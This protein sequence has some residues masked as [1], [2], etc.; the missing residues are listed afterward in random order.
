MADI[1]Y[2]VD[3]QASKGALSQSFA[4]SGVTANMS[5]AGIMSVTLNLGT[6][7]TQISTANMNV[8][9]ICI[10]RSLATSTTHTVSFGRYT[11]GTLYETATLRGGESM[12]LRLSAGDFAAK[13]AVANT[14]FVLHVLEG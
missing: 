5:T 9:G 12:V 14:Q 11:G 6:S 2:S 7:A 4:V 8:L 10:A 13:A 3:V 1:A